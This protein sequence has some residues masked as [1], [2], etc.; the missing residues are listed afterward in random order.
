MSINSTYTVGRDGSLVVIL[1]TGRI[2]LNYTDFQA[3]Q[4]TKQIV[5]QPVQSLT[6]IVEIPTMWKFS[7]TIDRNSPDLEK[8]IASQEAT[9]W[10]GGNAQ[11]NGSTI[12][13][14]INEIDGS[15]TT[16]QY[17]NCTLKLDDA[18][19]Y[20]QDDKITQ[21]LSGMAATRVSV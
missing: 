15:V 8:F 6:S 21:K 4:E 11:L 19:S 20:K 16:F 2:D 10:A 14:Y 13:Q 3:Q 18:G 12:Y 5:S 7:F 17:K 1:P 9:Y